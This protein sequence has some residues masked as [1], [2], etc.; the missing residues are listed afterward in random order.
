MKE[1]KGMQD[2]EANKKASL[3]KAYH[4]PKLRNYGNIRELTRN[5][6]ATS[7]EGASGMGMV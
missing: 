6:T 4:Q 7:G 1:H 3:K 5:V 2:K